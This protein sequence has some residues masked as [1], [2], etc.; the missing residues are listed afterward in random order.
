MLIALKKVKESLEKY[1]IYFV[2]F[3]VIYALTIFLFDYFSFY[4]IKSHEVSKSDLYKLG[5]IY[6]A[7]K[8]L[9]D[10]QMSIRSTN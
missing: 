3:L 4:R 10:Y 6:Y 8:D 1:F 2:I 7:R 9:F 5:Q